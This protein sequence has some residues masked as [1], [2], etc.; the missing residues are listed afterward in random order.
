MQEDTENNSNDAP[1]DP[2]EKPDPS[3]LQ[4]R[5]ELFPLIL[6]LVTRNPQM[7][8]LLWNEKYLWNKAVYL[9]ILGNFVFETEDP[10]MIREFLLSEKTKMLFKQISLCEK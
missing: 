9:I 8:S 1:D 3:F 4:E 7:F 5:T 2:T 6:C 10:A